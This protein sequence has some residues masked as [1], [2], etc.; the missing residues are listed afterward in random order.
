MRCRKEEAIIL[1]AF[2]GCSLFSCNPLTHLFL[3]PCGMDA[4][5]LSSYAHCR[6]TVCTLSC[7]CSDTLWEEYAMA[8]FIPFNPTDKYTVA[9]VK[10]R[11]WEVHLLGRVHRGV[12]QGTW[13]AHVLRAGPG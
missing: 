7:H 11:G 13:E 5:W 1:R 8:K 2:Q 10:V 4:P 12:C 9:F 3:T 6:L